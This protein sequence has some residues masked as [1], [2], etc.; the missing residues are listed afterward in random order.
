MQ[1]DG[2][3]GGAHGPKALNQVHNDAEYI[4]KYL[5]N[6]WNALQIANPEGAQLLT[7]PKLQAPAEEL[8]S[9]LKECIIKYLMCIKPVAMVKLD[10]KPDE[11]CSV[12][13]VKDYVNV[14]RHISGDGFRC[15]QSY[16]IETS[17]VYADAPQV[18]ATRSGIF[19]SQNIDIVFRRGEISYRKRNKRK[20]TRRIAS[21]SRRQ[22]PRRPLI[23]TL[24]KVKSTTA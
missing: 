11:D 13:A 17:N 6:L 21:A 3:V 16:K 7:M 1:L 20:W 19:I 14:L 22:R 23:W 12:L 9:A 15:L 8:T 24:S 5:P 4:D 10:S 2:I 18:Q